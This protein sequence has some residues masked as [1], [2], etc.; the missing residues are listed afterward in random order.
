MAL[1]PALG[2]GYPA[3]TLEVMTVPVG[4]VGFV[5]NDFLPFG[6]HAEHYA[7]SIPGASLTRL[8]EGEGHFMYLDVCHDSRDAGGVPL[9]RD[10]ESTA[11]RSMSVSD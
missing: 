5:Q 11:P 1:D 10:P 6:H 2:P 4:I 3:A 7:R 8:T 9:F